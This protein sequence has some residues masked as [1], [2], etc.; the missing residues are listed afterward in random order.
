MDILL[1][2]L[3]ALNTYVFADGTTRQGDTEAA[4]KIIDNHWYQERDGGVI[5]D[6]N[7]S[8]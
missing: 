6:P 5:V 7:V 4:Q 2:I 8:V 1:A 3:M